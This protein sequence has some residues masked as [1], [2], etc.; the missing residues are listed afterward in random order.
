[1]RILPN[2][3][4]NLEQDKVSLQLDKWKKLLIDF[5]KRNQL[6]YF[7]SRPSLTIEIKDEARL[8]FQKLYLESRSLSFIHDLETLA[9]FDSNNLIPMDP[10][11]LEP[12]LSY[13]EA[14]AEP[15][16]MDLEILENSLQSTKDIRS[17]D[18]TLNKLRQRALAS[19][20]EQGINILYLALYFLEWSDFNAETNE[21][22]KAKSPLFL[23]PVNLT[24]QGLNGAFRL[25]LVEDEIRINPTLD[26]K[27]SRDY[28]LN[29]SQFESRIN[30]LDNLEDF[31]DLI[32]EI[33]KLIT[34]AN[35]QWKILEESC[36]SVFSFA[37]LSLY[38]D[39]EDNASKI[40][41]H[42]IIKQIAGDN[43]QTINLNS[44]YLLA[45]KDLDYKIDA[46]E[47]KQ[48]LDAD[49][50]QEQAINAARSGLSFVIQGPPGTG[51]S[52]TIANIIAQALAQNKKI[53]FVS[54]K[55]AALD[56]VLSRLKNSKLDKFC[57]E[58]HNS[59]SK[60][61]D[62]IDSLKSS[63]EDIKN[64]ALEPSR[65]EHLED[66]NALRLELNT[67]VE[68]LHTI[69]QPVNKTL[70]ELYGK[71]KEYANDPDLEF[72]LQNIEAID[73]AKVN[74]FENFFK[75]IAKHKKIINNYD[76]F[77]WKDLAISSL[78]F[79]TENEIRNRLIEFK[80]LIPRLKQDS[81]ILSNKYFN[82]NISTLKE[83][84]WLKEAS[85]LILNSP[86][87]QKDWFDTTQI[88]NLQSLTLAAKFK[89]QEI[90]DEKQKLLSRYSEAFLQIDHENLLNI[91]NSRFKGVLKIFDLEYWKAINSIKKMSK[92]NTMLSFKALLEDLKRAAELDKQ[93]LM[94]GK[95]N[96][97]LSLGDFYKEFD[98]NW[99]ETLMALDWVK[100]ILS[101]FDSIS[102]KS[103]LLDLM[104]SESNEDD[105]EIFRQSAEK[106]M[107]LDQALQSC[108]N[109]HNELLPQKNILEMSFEE[110]LQNL[111][112]MLESIPEIEDWM[113]F[114]KL[115]KEAEALGLKQF[116]DALILD[117]NRDLDLV[118]RIFFR[119]FY[120]LWVDKIELENPILRKFNSKEQR[121]KID[122]FIKADQS[123]IKRNQQEISKSLALNWIEYASNSHHKEDLQNLQHEFNKKRKHKPMRI[124]IKELPSLLLSMK[125]CWM[126][127]PL[128]VSQLFQE[129]VLF[130]LVIFDE[131][132]QIRTEDAIS[133][134]YRSKQ[135]ILAGDSNQLPPT[136]FF[137][138]ISEDDDYENDNFESVLDE[139]SV[140]LD[141][142]TLN[143]H[144]RSRHEALISF[145]NKYIYN[146]KLI[147]FP[148]P[149]AKSQNFG[150]HFEYVEKAFYEKGSRHNRK[151][152]QKVAQAILEHFEKT[153]E[154]SLGVIAFSEAQQFAIER[155]LAKLIKNSS[156]APL[157]QGQL[158]H[159]QE[160]ALFIKN[161]ENVQGDERDII[162]FSIGY[163]KD[164]QGLLSHN[165]GP[166]NREGGHRRLNVAITRARNKIQIFSSIY[167]SDIDS[168]RTNAQGAILLKK[169][170]AFAEASRF[171]EEDVT[172]MK[173]K[174]SNFVD[175][176]EN[177]QESF[178]IEKSILEALDKL[179]YQ[180]ELHLGSSD[181]RI[182]IAIKDPKD[183]SRY[184]CG[185]QTDGIIYKNASTAR[186][187][188][189]LR[190]S[191]LQNL[192][193]K[194]FHIAARDW[195][196]NPQLLNQ[197]LESIN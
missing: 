180:A 138:Y 143:W 173:V 116:L 139:C 49:S 40:L 6:L 39:L 45:S 12:G 123:I 129:D 50:S 10:D 185:I 78:S 74:D 142:Y 65:Q 196:R 131:A 188:E 134:I 122:R 32:N 73:L 83:F 194:V 177:Q 42:P 159:G 27:L 126:M 67:Y 29:L 7:R 124:L 94:L 156:L 155:E 93:N 103:N 158:D 52:Q 133:A 167:A 109:F 197:I 34:K 59:Q 153:P 13:E 104:S 8:I 55:K 151:E 48:I 51:K 33:K 183:T 115:K 16:I 160:E 97:A 57:L 11:D 165:F 63:I 136:N 168:S 96:Y 86:F 144:Y 145:S 25:T 54:E 137:S 130:D 62:L 17:L 5:S 70:Y 26:Y 178:L 4:A 24:R 187:R 108:L 176:Y 140:F 102:I 149:I 60:K 105:F 9:N 46:F 128:S 163:A 92:A 91:F 162:Y 111:D 141:S 101:K 132:S 195:L 19:L 171:S 107:E 15:I 85:F 44:K 106:I 58:L 148:S 127:S 81:E 47:S 186:D 35:S 36:L 179:G 181:F 121:L 174:S 30:D 189:R 98:T 99:E 135:L 41:E 95:D 14:Q 72:T 56:V 154:Q 21:E 113:D 182:D 147:S 120:Q 68:N 88:A 112:Q 64:I 61:S 22:L 89:H 192:G 31:D 146:D 90:S 3:I 87:P 125:P 118:D 53:L 76:N 191:I 164:K 119:K 75:S 28:A 161:L 150:V 100:K 38:R 43:L 37:K 69:R 172:L 114:K 79:E 170:L 110:L 18:Q 82:K 166:L 23:L 152:A 169:Y 190:P 175:Y 117:S 80:N 71:L 1:M 157:I 2:N 193:W 184:L 66:I 20:Q 84:K 77:L